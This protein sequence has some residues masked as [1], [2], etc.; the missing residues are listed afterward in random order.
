MPAT[1][2]R[3][4]VLT[5]T[6]IAQPLGFAP[7]KA[8]RIAAQEA[9]RPVDKLVAKL[10]ETKTDA[11]RAALLDANKEL[12]TAELVGK[13]RAQGDLFNSQRRWQSAA[14]TFL[15]LKDVATRL[16]DDITIAASLRGIGLTFYGQNRIE[17]AIA[18]YQQSLVFCQ[19]GCS[20][21]DV[22]KTMVNL[23]LAYNRLSDYGEA[24][25]YLKRA[26]PLL[27]DLRDQFQLAA[28]FNTSG[29][30]HKNLGNYSAA[31]ASYQQA[32]AVFQAEKHQEGITG[33]QLNIGTVYLNVG[34]Y[35]QALDFFH[36]VLAASEA[37]DNKPLA[38][39]SLNNIGNVFYH[40]GDY[41]RALGFYESSLRLK[42]ELKDAIGAANSRSNIANIYQKQ[43]NFAQA[44]LWHQQAL[45]MR[46]ALNSSRGVI[47]SLLSLGSISKEQQEYDKALEYYGR[48]LQLSE[49]I[50]VVAL[51]AAS[52]SYLGNVYNEKQEPAK[53]LAT[54]DSAAALFTSINSKSGL[55]EVH[56]NQAATQLARNQ[57][58]EA[59]KFAKQSYALASELGNLYFQW[60]AKEVSGNA[61]LRLGETLRAQQEF[62]EA[63]RIIETMRS[64]SA[65][66]EA[67]SQRYFESMVGPYQGMVKSLLAQNKTAEAF[68]Y[69]ER[70][71]GRVLLDVLQNGRADV[72]KAMTREE[73]EQEQKLRIE[74]ASLNTQKA[75]ASQAVRPEPAKINDLQ[76]RVE[77]ARLDYDAFRG[78]LYAAHPELRIKRGD[79]QIITVE[80]TA[81]LLPDAGTALLSYI[82]VDNAVYLF[83]ITRA[84]HKPG[85]VVTTHTL[86]VG[87]EELS[88]VVGGFREQLAA[89]DNGFR[90]PARQLFDLLF[91]P[92][93]AQL[94]GKTNLVI[95]PD[96]ALWEL[97]F[98]TLLTDANRYVIEEAAVSYT[99]SFTVLREMMKQKKRLTTTIARSKLLAIGNPSVSNKTS[100]QT[101]ASRRDEPLDPLP[102]A[103]REVKALAQ[104]YSAAQSRVYT[105][106]EA[107][108]DRIKAEAN[109]FS[110][111]HFATHG[112]LNDRAPLYSHLVLSKGGND[113]DGLF[114]AWELMEMELHADLVV[115]SACETAR[116]RVG[117]GEGVIGL[118]WA[119]FVAGSPTTVVSQWKVDSAATSR[120]MLEFH[121]GLK[122]GRGGQA[123]RL[124]PASAL[125]TAALSL[126]RSPEYRHP[127]Y[128][129]GFSVVGYGQ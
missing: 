46:Q 113:E 33:T 22:V 66:G 90:Q 6:L 76:A 37:K 72:I 125:Q 61:L 81:T 101:A 25:A 96:A 121:K 34:E 38:S 69:G 67:E 75:Q 65:G 85:V 74:M 84:P 31:L 103:E 107:R 105:G 55:A 35:K 57:L 109:Q 114:E 98:H 128:W 60:S 94:Q 43:G 14:S 17:Q 41:A 115:L 104:L 68:S 20:N 89:R 50:G 123:S 56:Y 120:L 126:L 40:R 9:G 54:L 13:L 30:V 83:V 62:E 127:F 39:Q 124:V 97:P 88:R 122:R 29:L 42:E 4:F 129:A 92:A 18:S 108:E 51:R 112:I 82:V 111:L 2:C 19:T 77:K 11:D 102:E 26:E 100:Q 1:I 28:F 10:S 59:V 45:E 12:V 32:L 73:R 3:S 110:V 64:Q 48:A 79:A 23:A 49:E 86:P 8:S 70:A 106:A 71:K 53:A 27:A 80:Q 78:R 119:L 91:K 116:G 24:L 118:S 36:K 117:A 16:K 95:S 58:E 47:A 5:L 21:D 99:P 44:L 15:A 52:L 63:I 87:R 7:V 93:Q